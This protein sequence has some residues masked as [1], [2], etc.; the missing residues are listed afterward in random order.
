MK[1]QQTQSL[2]YDYLGFPY[3]DW[4]VEFESSDFG[5]SLVDILELP[6]IVYEMNTMLHFWAFIKHFVH[7]CEICFRNSE[8]EKISTF[9]L[10]MRVRL[11]QAFT[12]CKSPLLL[13]CIV[14][15][16]CRI[17]SLV[18]P[19]ITSLSVSDSAIISLTVDASD[20][21]GVIEFIIS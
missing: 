8:I 9:G 4:Y 18:S 1:D 12:K 14:D 19:A 20:D 5:A 7:N 13:F 6:P 11:R 21:I 2:V 16:A 3:R 10:G 17:S 15:T